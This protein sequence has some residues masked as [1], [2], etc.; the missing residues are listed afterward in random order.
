[1]VADRLLSGRHLTAR[2]AFVG[3]FVA[4]GFMNAHLLRLQASDDERRERALEGLILSAAQIANDA[5]QRLAPGARPEPRYSPD[6]TVAD[7]R[8]S[9]RTASFLVIGSRSNVGLPPPP[10]SRSG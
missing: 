9:Q 1:M 7:L 5:T 8:R 2:V 3:L 4:L 10:T 6:L